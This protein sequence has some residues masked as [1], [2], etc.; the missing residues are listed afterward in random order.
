M[1]DFAI[2]LLTLAAVFVVVILFGMSDGYGYGSTRRALVG[3]TYASFYPSSNG[4]ATGYSS[5]YQYPTAYTYSYQQP[6]TYTYT[7]PGY[8]YTYGTQSSM[9]GQ[10]GTGMASPGVSY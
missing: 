5:S 10:V 3:D 4:Y 6:S 2:I 7:M 9:D 1:R 8:T